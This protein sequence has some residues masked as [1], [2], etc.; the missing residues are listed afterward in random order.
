M[1]QMCADEDREMFE[2]ERDSQTYAIT[3][4][5]MEVHKETGAGLAEPIYQECFAVELGLRGPPVKRAVPFE[6]TYK[7]HKIEKKYFADL[8][9]YDSVSVECKALEALDKAHFQQVMNYLRVSGLQRGL[10]FNFG[11][12]QLEYKRIVLNYR[13]P[14]A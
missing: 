6:V 9:C 7:G 5:A 14:S 11:A 3:G 10:L 4:A 1:T 2:D 8:V 13:R 12:P